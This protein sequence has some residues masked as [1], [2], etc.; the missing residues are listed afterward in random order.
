[1]LPFIKPKKV[2]GLIVSQRMKDGRAQEISQEPNDEKDE[3]NQAVMACA[4]DLM[5]AIHAN[6]A[7]AV[8]QAL[9]SVFEIMEMAPHKEG[10]HIEDEGME[11]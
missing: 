4:H 11:Y 9:K 8:A 5:K 1:V 6:D 10:P 7:M 2:A 3:H